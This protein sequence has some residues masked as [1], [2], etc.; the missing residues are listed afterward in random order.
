MKSIYDKKLY[1]KLTIFLIPIL[2][3]VIELVSYGLLRYKKSYFPERSYIKYEHL[4]PDMIN[5]IRFKEPV[6]NK[7]KKNKYI[8][9]Y[10]LIKT[11]YESKAIDS[12]K[13]KGII[14]TGNSVSLGHPFIE[15]GLF[16]K[17]F[18]NLIEE[19]IRDKGDLFDM[20][21]LS[22][23]NFNSWEEKVELNR[24]LN[25]YNNYKNLPNIDIFASVGG[26]QDFWGFIDL[27]HHEKKYLEKDFYKANGLMTWKQRNKPFEKFYEKAYKSSIG[28]IFVSFDIFLNSFISFIKENSNTIEVMRRIKDKKTNQLISKNNE[29]YDLTEII[30]EKSLLKNI[31]ENKIGI[32]TSEYNDIKYSTILST[33]RN[34]R[35][36]SVI[37]PSSKIFF[38]YLPTRITIKEQLN[39]S[40]RFK[41]KKL[42]IKDLHIIE[43]DY[44]NSL[45]NGLSQIKNIDIINIGSIGKF[46]WFTDESH[47]SI[48]GHEKIAKILKPYFLNAL[49]NER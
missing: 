10:G 43:K 2:V 27:L 41:Y 21:N 32:T 34:F 29:K 48:K 9:K 49:S 45:I 14:I 22:F 40:N 28:N 44:R 6:N 5:G 3:F 11:F 1:F 7:D 24:Y 20:V 18:T 4:K 25:S 16:K 42:N 8:N 38:V 47:F 15:R 12:N 23:Y 30:N 46:D 13:N 36:I 35:S 37:I 33:V 31:I 26:I 17:T 39:I 19:G